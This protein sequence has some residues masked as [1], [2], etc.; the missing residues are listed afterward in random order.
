MNENWLNGILPVFRE[1]K[2]DHGED[3]FC[4][5]VSD[6]SSLIA[7]MDGCGGLGSRRYERHGG[8]TGA[9]IASR[10]VSETLLRWYE[11]YHPAASNEK[12]SSHLCVELQKCM[13]QAKEV[14][15]A[16]ARSLML[17]SMVRTLP[18]TLC[19]VLI[20]PRDSNTILAR[21]FGA[22]DSRGF[23]LTADCF[24]QITQDDLIGSPDAMENLFMDAPMS[25]TVNADQPVRLHDCLIKMQMPV[26]FITATDGVFSYFRSPMDFEFFLLDTLQCSSS[27]MEW[28]KNM[29]QVLKNVAADDYSMLIAPCG[30]TSFK[31]LHSSVRRRR[32]WLNKEY[33]KP[34]NAYQPRNREQI[35]QL[36]NQY[37]AY[38][39]GGENVHG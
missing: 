9:F 29:D 8:K 39:Y 2:Q 34:M 30:Y 38:Y 1:F 33:I 25:M 6:T 28:Q 31:Q 24:C 37:K 5:S 17:G 18:T 20:E 4:Y 21:F 15:Q 19:G 11:Q 32:E 3:S 12:N 26:M 35:A 22:G 36:W 16:E 23:V 14:L 10:L 27:L 7:V 13:N